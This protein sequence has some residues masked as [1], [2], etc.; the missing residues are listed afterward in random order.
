MTRSSQVCFGL[1]LV[2]S[3]GACSSNTAAPQGGTGGQGQGGA[4]STGGTTG[5]GGGSGGTTASTQT[6]EG[7]GTGT[8]GLTGTGGSSTTATGG[9]TTTGGS[10]GGGSTGVTGGAGGTV[11]TGGS[12]ST[13]TGGATTTGGSTSRGGAGGGGGTT[14]TG[15][16]GGTTTTG[17]SGP[18]SGGRSGTDAGSDGGP[19]GT[20]GRNTGGS[21]TGGQ[22]NADAS[23]TGGSGGGTG[24]HPCPTSGDACKILPFGDSI[25]HGLQSSDSAGYRSQLFKLV[26]AANQNITFTGSQSSGPATVSGKTFPKNHEGRDGWT[27]DPGY[28]TYGSGGISSLVPSPAFNTI[29]N[30][31]LL[32]IGTNDITSTSDPGGTI[33]RLDKLIDKI[34]GAA[35]D[36]LVV[37]AQLVPVSWSSADLNNYNA[38]IPGIVQTHAGKGQ[39]VVAVDM[40]K[41]PTSNLASDGVH[42]NDQGYAYMAN[43]WYAAIK[44]VLP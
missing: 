25:T 17:G 34:A 18:G 29:P 14:A 22:G 7:G 43:I 15:G 5:S 19:G 9:A 10:T 37:V 2:L 6:N 13:T 33:N 12:S 3:L 23:T 36:A 28:S 26:V 8:G 41:M 42:P 38:K 31:V 4:S 16:T 39:H 20:G 11:A 1:L 30:I 44:D 35:P 21:G 32:H 27:V 24:F 40:S